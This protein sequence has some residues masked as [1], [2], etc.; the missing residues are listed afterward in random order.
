MEG[1]RRM[2]MRPFELSILCTLAT[3]CSAGC[4][5]S[6]VGDDPPSDDSDGSAGVIGTGGAKPTGGSTGTGGAKPTGGSTGTG[7]AK[8]TGGSTGTGGSAGEGGVAGTG[9]GPPHVVGACDGLGSAGT[10]DDITPAAG[11]G[12]LHVLADPVNA[13]T[14][15]L[16]TANKGVFKS[17]NCGA[18]WT[19]I[20][21]G[22]NAGVI[23]SGG[24]WSMEIDPVEP[25]VLYAGSLYGSDPSL[26]KSTNGGVD[27]DSVFPPGSEVAQTVENNFFQELSMDPTDH[28]HIVVSFHANCKGAYAPMCMAE[29]KDSGGTWRLFKGPVSGW[30]ENARPFVLGA[31]SFLYA[32]ALDGLFFSSDN[33]ATWAKV[34]AGGNHQI[35]RAEDGFYYLGQAY[36]LNRSTDGRTWTKVDGA[37]GGDGLMG[38]GTRLFTGYRDLPPNS[39]QPYFTALETDGTKWAALPSPN[40]GSGPVWFAVDRDHHV[41]YTA[42][43]DA[44][45]WRMVIQ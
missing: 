37:P 15:Y 9:G 32:T 13:G 14:V 3:V 12:V 10:W 39:Q 43:F 1:E 35:Y 45:A 34:G 7:G 17:T 18:A 2:T 38:D 24:Q 33:G 40:M 25:N 19:K 30:G 21:T 29:T 36:G 4:V 27:W 20:N 11:M 44:G 26:Q 41:F 5:A 42:N 31:T 6:D 8:A 23:D 16:G 28:R 22:R